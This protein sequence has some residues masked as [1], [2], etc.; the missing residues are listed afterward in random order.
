MMTQARAA[1]LAAIMLGLVGANWVA[2]QIRALAT[3]ADL[4]F[5]YVAQL[6]FNT[7]FLLPLPVMLI[8]LYRSGA[9]IVL[10]ANLRRLALTTA[11]VLGVVFTAPGL[12]RLLGA[13]LQDWSRLGWFGETA[14]APKLWHWFL[15]NNARNEMWRFIIELSQLAVALFLVT[16]ARSS[17]NAAPVFENRLKL[18]KR[19]AT[20]ATIAAGIAVMLNVAGQ[21]SAAREYARHRE[22]NI[23]WGGPTQLEF[24]FRNFLGGI[25][26]LCRLA[27]PLIIYMSLLPEAPSEPAEAVPIPS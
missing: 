6:F 9:T 27:I 3:L 24:V 26:E 18:L 20:V 1:L 8:F 2:G 13:V 23:F 17:S 16:L 11:F 12:Y 5:L 7:L 4:R 21:L 25:P 14:V 19:A 22:D 10:S 15:S